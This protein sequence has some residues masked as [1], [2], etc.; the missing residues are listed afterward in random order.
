MLTSIKKLADG[1]RQGDFSA[2]ELARYYL[3]RIEQHNPAL[4]AFITV[5][6]ETALAQAEAAVA[7]YASATLAATTCAWVTGT[8]SGRTIRS[9][10]A[11]DSDA[12]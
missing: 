5:T 8:V 2:V 3:A 6:P 1:L 4:N 12:P 11:I 10:G 7:N 9:P